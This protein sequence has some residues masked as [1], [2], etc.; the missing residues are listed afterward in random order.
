MAIVHLNQAEPFEG[1]QPTKP[2]M[3]NQMAGGLVPRFRSCL[4]NLIERCRHRRFNLS[5]ST[6]RVPQPVLKLFLAFRLWRRV[7][8]RR[9]NLDAIRRETSRHEQFLPLLRL[10]RR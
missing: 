1:I 2:R 4:G 3:V 6:D 5:H 9:W 8:R 7:L 10:S